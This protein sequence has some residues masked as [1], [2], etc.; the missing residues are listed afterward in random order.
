MITRPVFGQ[1][2]FFRTTDVLLLI[3]YDSS[4]L[5]GSTQLKAGEFHIGFSGSGN[6]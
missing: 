1:L 5:I 2:S 4:K 6:I 3:S